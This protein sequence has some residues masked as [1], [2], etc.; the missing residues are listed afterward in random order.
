MLTELAWIRR[1][2]HDS[3]WRRRNHAAARLRESVNGRR[4]R[5]GTTYFYYRNKIAA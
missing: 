1:A 2:R 4:G 5:S 3:R